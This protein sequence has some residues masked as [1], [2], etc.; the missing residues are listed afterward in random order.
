MYAVGLSCIFSS[1]SDGGRLRASAEDQ[2]ATV[3]AFRAKLFRAFGVTFDKLTAAA[4]SYAALI[5]S[6]PEDDMSADALYALA[7]TQEALKQPNEALATLATFGSKY[8]KHWLS[9]E[10]QMRQAEILF[11]KDS[12]QQAL[13]LFSQVAAVT[14]FRLSDVAMLRQARCLYELE[15]YEKAGEVYWDVPRKFEQ[16]KHYDTAVL[17]GGKCFFLNGQYEVARTGLEIVAK[18]DVPEAA[19]AKM[20]I[21]RSF[22]K[23]GDA[24]KALATID[25]AIA[26]HSDSEELSQLLLARVDAIYEI[27]DRRTESIGLYASFA[28]KYPDHDQAA[29]AQ[30]MASLAALDVEDHAAAKTHSDTFLAKHQDDRLAPDVL[31]VGAEA[32]LMLKDYP[33]ASAQYEE[34]LSVGSGHDNAPQARVRLG[35]AL[36]LEG[37]FEDAAQWLN[38]SVNSIEDA[39]LKSEALAL[40]GRSYSEL[41][42][43][44]GAAQALEKSLTA[45]PDRAQTDETLLALSEAYRQLGRDTDAERCLG[46]LVE[47]Y[48]DS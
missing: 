28:A 18:R 4:E 47:K 37:E 9:T 48:P 40:V 27:P 6:F 34:F 46:Q 16:T 17:A 21:G 32:R 5:R 31:F 22:L 42:N 10:V 3:H 7:V 1:F 36:H 8:P 43:F 38:A 29:Q 26:A 20:W 12:F 24:A 39:T 33:G 19:E 14:E 35:L 30:Y 13:T 15:D 25:A 23:D 11:A 41:K 2:K 44:N 45:K